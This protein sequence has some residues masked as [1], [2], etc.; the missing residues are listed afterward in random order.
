M[1]QAHECV[2]ETRSRRRMFGAR[3]RLDENLLGL[4][5]HGSPGNQGIENCDYMVTK[6]T[7]NNLEIT[8]D[9]NSRYSFAGSY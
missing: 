8:A 9:K 4:F 2:A 1:P 3:H 6:D 5:L 7:R